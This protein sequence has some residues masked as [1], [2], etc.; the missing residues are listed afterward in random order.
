[1]GLDASRKDDPVAQ[2]I[3][4]L[5]RL[6][7][8]SDPEMLENRNMDGLRVFYNE[9]GGGEPMNVNDTRRRHFLLVDYEVLASGFGR[10]TWLKC[11]DADYVAENYV[12]KNNRVTQ[13]YF[14]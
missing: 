1:M 8:R 10:G 12:P 4:N 3:M 7:V 6:D 2:H 11:V 9:S 14:G 13:R 5:F